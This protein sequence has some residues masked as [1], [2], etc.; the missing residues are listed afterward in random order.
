M[1]GRMSKATLKARYEAELVKVRAAID[2]TLDSNVQS[3]S[4]EI[5]SLTRL[6]IEQ[7]WAREEKL[8]SK[9]ERLD[10]G[11]RFGKLGFTRVTAGDDE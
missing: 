10:R 7:L 11:T 2:A 3:Y 8:V 6:G 5:Q 9:I 1:L 4:T